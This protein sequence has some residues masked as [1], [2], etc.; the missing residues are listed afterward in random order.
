[1]KGLKT[2]R[3]PRIGALAMSLALIISACSGGG[4]ESSA[5]AASDDAPATSGDAS[6]GASADAGAPDVASCLPDQTTVV[7]H[8]G[9]GGGGDL[10]AREWIAMLEAEEIIEP[11]SWTV[12]NR[13]GGSGAVAVSYVNEQAGRDDMIAV[14]SNVWL[15]NKLAI[16]GVEVNS[17]DLTQIA[18]MLE[19]SMAIAV[20]ADS[21]Y[22]SL[23]DFV[24][25]AEAAPGELVQ[26]GGSPTAADSL[27]KAVLENETG[28]SWQFLSFESGGDRKTALLRG[29]A[30]IFMSEPLDLAEDVEA[31]EMRLLATVGDERLGVFPDTPTTTELGYDYEYI[32]QIRGVL[33]PPEMPAEASACYT[34]VFTQLHDTESWTEYLESTSAVDTFLPGE[35]YA[36]F[37]EGQEESVRPILDEL[38]ILV[39]GQ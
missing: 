12:E 14:V 19:D 26:A 30:Q 24:A 20:G 1:M 10:Q 33:A 39:E 32:V 22:E 9:P 23:D 17:L 8:T 38:G 7:V 21:E 3:T 29:D 25:A 6:T 31:G 16:E 4:D 35:E 36:T 34:E 2:I 18:G 15:F 13:E 28:A 11:G 5:P 37:L 27:V